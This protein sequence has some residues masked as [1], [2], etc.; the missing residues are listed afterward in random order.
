MGTQKDLV[1]ACPKC[2]ARYRVDAQRLSPQGG[3]LRC[4]R[5]EAVFR[6]TPPSAQTPEPPDA[7]IGAPQRPGRRGPVVVI[8]DQ[9]VVA[10]KA[11]ADVLSAWGFEPVL[12][13]DG[14]EAILTIQRLLP[15]V[16]VLDTGLPKMFGYQV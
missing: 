14:G 11:M 2:G 1:A 13:H 10:G 5:C 3:R 7:P 15:A 16:A 9:D 4:A 6:V 12:G 8:A